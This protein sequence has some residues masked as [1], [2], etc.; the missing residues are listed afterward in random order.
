MPRKRGPARTSN[1][2]KRKHRFRQKYTHH[3]TPVQIKE[4]LEEAKALLQIWLIN[5][6][7]VELQAMEVSPAGDQIPYYLAFV[8]RV[9]SKCMHF[10]SVTYESEKTSLK[11]EFVLRGLEPSVLD[12]LI[13]I[14]DLKCE[15]VKNWVTLEELLNQI[16][17][18]IGIVHWETHSRNRV[19]PQ[20]ITQ[21]VTLTAA[22]VANTFGAWAEIIPLNTV[23]FPFHVV[24]FCICQVSAIGHYFIQ[25]G[26]NTVLA[27]PGVNMEMGERRLRFADHPIARASELLRIR[28]QGIPANSRVMGRLKTAS[29]NADTAKITVVITRHLDVSDE[30]AIWPAFPW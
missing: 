20:D 10:S 13:S 22:A 14:A 23:P 11:T 9:F 8:K 17:K 1:V 19:Y 27:D 16:L 24:G 2:I 30:P 4:L 7:A 25:L 3:V 15:A 26:H 29:G 18:D 21:N 6:D 28:G 12:A 5:Y